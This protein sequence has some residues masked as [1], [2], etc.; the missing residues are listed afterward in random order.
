MHA[1]RPRFGIHRDAPGVNEGSQR[2]RITVKAEGTSVLHR[3]LGHKED[4]LRNEFLRGRNGIEDQIEL[5]DLKPQD[6]V[7]NELIAGIRWEDDEY[8]YEFNANYMLREPLFYSDEGYMGSRGL[9]DPRGLASL[10]MGGQELSREEK[11]RLD[12]TLKRMQRVLEK[13]TRDAEFTVTFSNEGKLTIA[14]Q[15]DPD[16]EGYTFHIP[17]VPPNPRGIASNSVACLHRKQDMSEKETGKTED[18]FGRA[19]QRFAELFGYVTESLYELLQ[20]SIPTRTI[21]LKPPKNLAGRLEAAE[22]TA[23]MRKKMVS[24]QGLD[25]DEEIQRQV[26]EKVSLIER[27]AETFADIGGNEK[28]KEELETVVAALRDPDIF[29]RR[30][31]SA[32]RGVLLFGEPG[33]GKTM[34]TKALAHEADAGI[35]V[36]RLADVLHSL[37]GR[38][39]RLLNEVFK[40]AREHAPVVILIDELDALGGNRNQSNEITSRIVTVLTT[41]MDGLEERSD[42]IVVVGTTNR[43][44]VIDPALKRPG[45]LDLLIEVPLPDKPQ[46]EQIFRLKIAKAQKIA[47]AANGGEIFD[48]LDLGQLTDITKD[49]SGADIEEVIRRALAKKVREEMKGKPFLPLTTAELAGVIAGYETVRKVRKIG[50]SQ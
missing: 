11:G 43:V 39:E 26:S 31:T 21:E 13:R 5:V 41:N 35:Y 30:G 27:P 3:W 36:V 44:E 47:A 37:Y 12:A 46:R 14:D 45:R 18:H 6:H 20:E 10:L 17:A 24:S 9:M 38:T 42:G 34:L 7:L 33:T 48:S 49:F 16:Y 28:A 4:I 25:G 23:E 29:R 32:P 8:G 19:Y 50:F 22:G 1:D 2:G 15:T 40:Q